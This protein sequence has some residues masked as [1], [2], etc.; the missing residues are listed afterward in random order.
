MVYDVIMA[1]VYTSFALLVFPYLSRAMCS[2]NCNTY[3]LTY[4]R[5]IVFAKFVAQS[6]HLNSYSEPKQL[7]SEFELK[8]YICLVLQ[9]SLEIYHSLKYY[10]IVHAIFTRCDFLYIILCTSIINTFLSFV[11]HLRDE[12][13][14]INCLFA[15]IGSTIVKFFENFEQIWTSRFWR[16]RETYKFPLFDAL[17]IFKEDNSYVNEC[18]FLN[19]P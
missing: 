5:T 6:G 19:L 9:V 16:F 2:L 10:T 12:K 7:Y 15:S 3:R 8:K 13:I 4:S 11:C 18:F 14:L 17:F 1:D